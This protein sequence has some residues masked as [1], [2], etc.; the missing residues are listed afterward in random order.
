[1][2]TMDASGFV[3]LSDIAPDVIQEIRY[4][5]TYN[6]VGD[7]IDGY[8]EPVAL[9]TRPAAEALK[10]VSDVFH[11]LGYRIKIFDTY[12]P[13][14][15]ADHFVRWAREKEDIRMKAVF[16]PEVDK[17]DLFRLGFIA[18]GDSDHSRGST[19]DLTLLDEITGKEVD[20]GGVFDY[21]GA[22]SHP[23]YREGL[24]K[25]QLDNR[26]LLR[27]V[28]LENGFRGIDSEWWHFTLVNEPYPDTYF[29]FPVA[30][31]V[32]GKGSR[33]TMEEGL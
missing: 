30:S 4:H 18:E 33:Q 6:F 25:I 13:R 19:A 1:M 26:C 31:S 12:R 14:R 29:S 15:A 32:V 23:D 24:T 28:M 5:S 27:K 22:V 8:E 10:K 17:A 2:N 9:M 16:Y 7:R 11:G 20:M 3:V 21:F